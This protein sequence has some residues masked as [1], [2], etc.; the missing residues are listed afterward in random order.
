K[1][2]VPSG[3]VLHDEAARIGLLTIAV[4]VGWRLLAPKKLRV[5]PA[6]LLAII[7]GTVA[8]LAL[9]WAIKRV[10]MPDSLEE[11]TTVITWPT[12][13]A[14]LRVTEPTVL[15]AIFTVAFVASAETLLCATAV[16]Q[17]HQG[18]RTKYDKELAA[19]GVG[20]ILCG[21]LGALPMTGVI[22]RSAAN[23]EAGAK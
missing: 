9:G 8:C 7:A 15:T 20:N 6:P 14:L 5:I 19:Q 3:D 10:P 4:L 1:G 13:E 16:D 18:P 2:V 22:V 17:L 21:A 23:V 12:R 11:L